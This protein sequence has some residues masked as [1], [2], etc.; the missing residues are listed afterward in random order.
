MELLLTLYPVLCCFAGIENSAHMKI[1]S[2]QPQMQTT[3]L[4][5]LNV[6]MMELSLPAVNTG[7]S[8]EQRLGEA[9]GYYQ[10]LR[11]QIQVEVVVVLLKSRG[12]VRRGRE[13]MTCGHIHVHGYSYLTSGRDH[14]REVLLIQG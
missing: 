5:F 4:N 6:Q 8:M 9:E 10:L 11:E 1:V 3:Y 7:V 14:Y 12:R 13:G 2:P